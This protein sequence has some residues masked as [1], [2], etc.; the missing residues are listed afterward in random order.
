MTS[1]PENLVSL[2]C[3]EESLRSQ[4]VSQIAS[5]DEL[6]HHVDAL[7]AGMDLLDIFRQTPTN[8][9][10][11]NLIVAIGIRIFNDQATVFKL[12]MSGYYQSAALIMRDI[13]ECIFL[14]DYFRSNPKK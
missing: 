6:S 8:N 7:E 11:E 4:S 1:L 10:D 2:H 12:A 9:E 14:V 13:L 3:E 5:D